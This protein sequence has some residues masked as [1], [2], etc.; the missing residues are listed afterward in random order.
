[1]PLEQ[2]AQFFSQG[3]QGARLCFVQHAGMHFI[4]D[5]MLGVIFGESLL[6]H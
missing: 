5:Y 6:E 4:Q 1:M 2:S 3:L